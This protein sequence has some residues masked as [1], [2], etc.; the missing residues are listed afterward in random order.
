MEIGCPW[1]H[2]EKTI[3]HGLTILF[4]CL[5]SSHR[6]LYR[7]VEIVKIDAT[8]YMDYFLEVC[9]LIIAPTNMYMRLAFVRLKPKNRS[10]VSWD[11]NMINF[12][13]NIGPCEFACEDS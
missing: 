12:G 7:F 2:D 1:H 9:H 3:P 11:L 8:N 6:M 13:K 5:I 10:D 4:Y